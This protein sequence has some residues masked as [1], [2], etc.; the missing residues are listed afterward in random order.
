MKGLPAN[1]KT[2]GD[3]YLIVRITTRRGGTTLPPVDV[4]LARTPES[5]QL[6]VIG[7]RRH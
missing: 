4:H 3:G 7:I 5:G 1:L 2:G 6:R